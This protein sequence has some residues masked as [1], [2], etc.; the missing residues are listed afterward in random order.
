MNIL[1]Q[2]SHP[3]HF[4]LYKNVIKNLQADGHKVFILIKS[5]DILE[6]LLKAANLQYYNILPN[7]KRK[8]KFDILWQMVVK[9]WR[10]LKFCLKHKIDLLTGSTPEAAQIGW[11]LRKYSVNLIEDDMAVVPAWEKAAGRFVQ[12]VVSPEVCNNGKLER[13]SVKYNGFQ[14]LAYLHPNYFTPDISVVK[15]YFSTEKNYFLLR[16]AKLNAYHDSGID[17]ISTEIAE[18]IIKILEKK[19]NIYITSERELE[20]Q[21]ERYRLNINPLDIHHI[22]AFA[23]MYIGDSQSMAVEAAMLGVPSIRF[24]DFA[25][26]IGV[27]EELEQKYRLTFGI[28]SDEPEKFYK[29]VE[30]LLDMPDLSEIFQTRR[31]KMLSEKIDVTEFL[32]WFFENYPTSKLE[33]NHTIK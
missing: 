6:E 22:M 3:A 13:K 27:L 10:I 32:T 7:Y 30:N 20:P 31:Q 29:M 1:V 4:H 14:K 33:I 8:N 17:G 26:R 18:N 2:L 24:N 9:D 5:K 25:G 12:T 19:G 21:F 11:L 23:K 16:F 28:K 15:K